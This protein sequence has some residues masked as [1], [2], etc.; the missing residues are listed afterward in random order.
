MSP[1]ATAK[2]D[3]PL[4]QSWVVWALGA[5][6]VGFVALLVIAGL[7]LLQSHHPVCNTNFP[8]RRGDYPTYVYVF[9][10]IAMFALGSLTSS[11]GIRRNRR[12]QK[13]LGEG[14]WTNPAAVVN[15]NLAVAIFL[16]L[17]TILMLIGA[18]TLGPGVRP[19]RSYCEVATPP[20]GVTP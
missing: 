13:M 16:F 4:P 6:A 8:A 15:V 2:D 5:V 14:P 18:R 3:E 19:V 11:V 17:L 12:S 10:A 9:A 7:A 20:R 1:K